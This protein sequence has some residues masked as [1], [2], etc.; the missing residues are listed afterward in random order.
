MFFV[1]LQFY[2]S[3]KREKCQSLYSKK[4]FQEISY[5][6]ELLTREAH[7]TSEGHITHLCIELAARRI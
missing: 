2:Y 5:G 6:F 7:I 1:G 4:Y 3:I